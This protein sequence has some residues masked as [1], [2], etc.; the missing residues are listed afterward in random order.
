MPPTHSHIHLKDWGLLVLLSVVW[1]GS[2][3]FTGM[4]VKEL[5]PLVIVMARVV[6]AAAALLPLHLIL[7]GSLPKDRATW[8]AIIGLSILNNIIPFTLIVTGQTM[9]A[10]GLASV[11]NATSPLFGVAFLALSGLEPLVARKVAGIMI[12]IIGVVILK[13]ANLLGS[14]S[15]SFGILLCLGAAA[16][17]GAGSLWAKMKLTGTAPLSMATG[18][19]LISSVI[20]LALAFAFSEPTEL[21]HASLASWLAILG[22]ALIAT[23]FAYIIFF[24]V[25]ARAGPANVL[26]VTMMI[27]VSAI[28]MGVAVLGETIEPMEIV[29]A[30]VIILALLIIDGRA[31]SLVGLG[32]KTA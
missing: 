21:L 22:L 14:S 25:V 10:S 8:V 11:I 20:M 3:L 5:S 31:L 26:L 30:I 16:S 29:G 1:G 19:L 2:F 12:G 24:R 17:Y 32:K 13:G 9:I 27:P 6:I 4:A 7:I 15:E 28:A 23:S 18:Q